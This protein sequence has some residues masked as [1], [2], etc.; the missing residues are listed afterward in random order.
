MERAFFSSLPGCPYRIVC[1]EAT[2]L[3]ETTRIW[4]ETVDNLA[5]LLSLA[6]SA[7]APSSWRRG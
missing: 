7:T 3:L 6:P 1:D 2:R 4:P 5:P